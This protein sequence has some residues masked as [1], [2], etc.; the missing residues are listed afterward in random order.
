MLE[1]AP[2]PRQTNRSH[3]A[4]TMVSIGRP[5]APT[6]ML[7]AALL[8]G[9]ALAAKQKVGVASS[10]ENHVEGVLGGAVEKLS[11]GSEVFD[12]Q[13]VRT[14]EASKAGLRFLDDTTL[15]LSARSEVRLDRFVY[16]GGKSGAL[17][18][19]V[20]RGLARFV[21][22]SLD[23]RAY[24][25]RTPIATIGVRGTVFDV[26]T[27]QDRMTALL[28]SGGISIRTRLGRTYTLRTP[29]SAITIHRDGRV[30]RPR[31]STGPPTEFAN[32][33]LPAVVQ[34]AAGGKR[35]ASTTTLPVRA[36]TLPVR[37]GGSTTVGGNRLLSPG[38]LE[39]GGG[40]TPQAP[41]ATGT[42]ISPTI[43]VTP[44]VPRGGGSTRGGLR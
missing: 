21:T 19:E 2:R 23:H 11:A 34:P 15:S 14:G 20:P 33:A 42:P 40:F 30:L 29:N 37:S 22:G 31:A 5:L 8:P 18:V 36:G 44:T 38:L 4:T 25:V 6:V 26:L 12:S 28:V 3:E 17:V 43:P 24:A 32:L 16:Q 41:A 39:G 9:S 10:V 1:P 35:K 13:L 27:R 7:L